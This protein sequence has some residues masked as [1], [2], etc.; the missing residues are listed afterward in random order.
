LKAE[1]VKGPVVLCGLVSNELEAGFEDEG[2][3]SVRW[4]CEG[5]GAASSA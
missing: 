4:C 2:E 5:E 1:P 3:C